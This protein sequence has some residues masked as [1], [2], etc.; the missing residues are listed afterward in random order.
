MD[1]PDFL[2][3]RVEGRDDRQA[4]AIRAAVEWHARAE[5]D[6]RD[7]AHFILRQFASEWSEHPDYDPAWV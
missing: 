3:A 1:L 7:G 5:G 2:S 4:D 6:E